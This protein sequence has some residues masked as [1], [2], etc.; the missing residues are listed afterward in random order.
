MGNLMVKVLPFP[1]WLSTSMLPSLASGKVLTTISPSPKPRALVVNRGS[2][3]FSR[4]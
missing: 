1:T 3:I 2:K 4:F